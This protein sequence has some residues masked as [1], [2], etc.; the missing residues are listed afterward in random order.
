MCF[1][2]FL[3]ER[4]FSYSRRKIFTVFEQNMQ[5]K[6]CK[7]LSQRFQNRPDKLCEL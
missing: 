5:I 4:I 7:I 6:V 1:I 3:K 2:M